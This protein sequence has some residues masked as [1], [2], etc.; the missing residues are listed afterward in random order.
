MSVTLIE[1]IT[2]GSA[3]RLAA[4]RRAFSGV[5][6]IAVATGDPERATR[7]S[8]EMVL[9]S[10]TKSLHSPTSGS[11]LRFRR[12]RDS[13]YEIQYDSYPGLAER[14]ISVEFLYTAICGSL[15]PNCAYCA[16]LGVSTFH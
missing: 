2:V 6:I 3:T 1:C 9:F 10:N 14:P 5:G 7:A 11:V 16:R 12:L 13:H 8:N 4:Y 15:F